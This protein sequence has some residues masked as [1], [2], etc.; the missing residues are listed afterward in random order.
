MISK[1]HAA[2]TQAAAVCA[3]VL[4]TFP[5]VAVIAQEM[6]PA[7]VFTEEVRNAEFHDQVSL[8]GRTEAWKESR[9]VSEVSGRVARID[10]LEGTWVNAGEPLVTL[11]SDRLRLAYEAKA[12][13]ARQAE[14]DKRIKR[15][16]T[17][18]T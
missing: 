10:A 6:P 13:E 18:L 1:I 7:L 2:A 15:I 4:A 3:L 17:T 14:N 9:I 5:G 12:A 8:V 11:E 16:L